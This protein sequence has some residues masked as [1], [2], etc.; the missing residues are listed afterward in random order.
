MAEPPDLWAAARAVT[1]ARIGLP[2]AGASLAT[3]S[4]LAFR[5]A[6]ARARDAVHMVLDETQLAADLAAFGCQPML[7]AS[8]ADD[9]HTYLLRPDLGRQLSAE[10]AARLVACPSDLAIVIA[11]GLSAG[12]VQAHAVPVLAALMPTLRR[13]WKIAPPVIVRHGRVGIGDAIA[14][15]LGAAAVLVLIGERPGLSAPDSLGAYLTWHPGPATTD[16]NRNCVS[17]IRPNGTPPHQAAVRIGALLAGMRRLGFSGVA[18][19]DET[20]AGNLLGST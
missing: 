3:A 12:A 14:T 2:R 17:N 7:L 6:H 16:A 11:D 8:A 20:D 18:L 5:L 13:D 1:P 4:L 15:R 19:K 10:L 9:R